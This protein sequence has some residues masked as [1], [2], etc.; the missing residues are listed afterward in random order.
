VKA[1]TDKLLL[2]TNQIARIL[3]VKCALDEM[4]NVAEDARILI[5]FN[6]ISMYDDDNIMHQEFSKEDCSYVRLLPDMVEYRLDEERLTDTNGLFLDA[7]IIGLESD[8]DGPFLQQ[9][10][11]P[12]RL[13]TGLLGLF[14][15]RHP[16][17]E[18]LP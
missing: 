8:R 9:R 4:C 7:V 5:K 17:L 11:E 14:G 13:T 12:A 2:S 15:R 16:T 10:M 1:Q 3:G 18:G 6:L